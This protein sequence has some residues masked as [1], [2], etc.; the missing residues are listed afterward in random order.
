MCKI[1]LLFILFPNSR[2][3]SI[4]FVEM[5]KK[6]LIPELSLP[7][8]SLFQQVTAHFVGV[9]AY[10][11]LNCLYVP[12]NVSASGPKPDLGWQQNSAVQC[13][14]ADIDPKSAANAVAAA[15]GFSISRPPSRERR[16]GVDCSGSAYCGPKQTFDKRQS[17]FGAA[18]QTGQSLQVRD[19]TLPELASQQ[20]APNLRRHNQNWKRLAVIQSDFSSI[21]QQCGTRLLRK[22]GL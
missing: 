22:D 11:V 18:L 10:R 17:C 14:V 19:H 2:T 4:T 3:L 13:S 9:Q 7:R 12:S 15:C 16:S 1:E 8:A 6:A 20:L 21:A 5:D